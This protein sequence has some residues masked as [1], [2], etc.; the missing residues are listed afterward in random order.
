MPDKLT[1]YINGKWTTSKD[2][3]IP[4]NDAGF[5]YGDG[6]FETIRFDNHKPFRMEKHIARLKNGCDVLQLNLELNDE[7]IKSIVLEMIKKNT[8]GNGLIRLM[9]TRGMI[10]G[11]PWNYTGRVGVYALIRPFTRDPDLPVK[12]VYYQETQYPIIRFNPAVKSMNYLG[13][14]LAK[15]DAEKENA[16]EPVFIN[17]DGFITECA[18]RNIFFIKD[19]TL[20]TPALSLGILPGVMRDTIIEI[21]HLMKLE[22]LEAQIRYSEINQ[23]SEAF[24]SSTG[25]GLYP[26][27]WDGWVSD[28][29]IT[30]RIQVKLMNVLRA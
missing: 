9:I 19:S 27:F 26:C 4:F 25:I 24:I 11:S 28:Y 30:N 18:I 13:N 8:L 2:A 10:T 3:Q 21:A 20:I 22:V 17:H 15:K 5:L 1:Y 23:M 6:L 14:L 16:F 7:E 29:Q 12:V